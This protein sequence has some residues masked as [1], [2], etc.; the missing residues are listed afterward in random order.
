MSTITESTAIA[1]KGGSWLI[2]DTPASDIF[3]PERL[4]DEHRLIARTALDFIT[5]EV[6]PRADAL[7]AKDWKVARDLIKRCGDL[8]LMGTDV[9]EEF[10]GVDL[11]KAA[12][13]VVAEGISRNASFGTAFG[14]MTSLSIMPLLCFGTEAQKR[15][16][17][18][19]LVNGEIVG[20][21]ALS[22]SGSGSD[23]LG[24]KARATRQPDGSFRLNGEK[25]WI[26]NAGFADVF[27]VFAKVDGEQFT[28]FIVERGFPGVS[29]GKEEH[30]MGLHGSSTAPLI[31]QDAQVPADNLLGDIG[32]GHRVAFNVLNYGRFKLGAMA[33]G[34]AKGALA[35]AAK[36][37]ATR[38]QFGRALATF[39]AI[40]YKLAEMT[41]RLY[42]LESLLYR[43]SGLIDDAIGSAGGNGVAG[44]G[45]N[46]GASAGGSTQAH[47]AAL[48]EFA[49]ESSIAKV[50]GSEML[51]Y[52]IDEN[53]QIHGGNGYVRDYPAE[54]HYRDSRVNRIFEGTNEINRMLIT[55]MLMRRAVKG[56]IG[57]IAAAKALQDE[58]MTPSL[59]APGDDLLEA[60][61]FVVRS[62]KKVGLMLLGTAM[63]TYG[64]KVSD[65]QEILSW[66]SDV[67][68]DTFAGESAVLRALQS[69][70]AN[71]PT[72]ALQVDAARLFVS[73]AAL[74]I[75]AAA[76]QALAGMADGDTLR[77]LLAAL[78]RL[79]KVAPVNTITIRR[80]ISDA[81]VE[82][83]GYPLQF[84]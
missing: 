43:T 54:R 16:Y 59:D 61:Q 84:S 71:H 52:V 32:K 79:L 3:T 5:Q 62:F 46:G 75:E 30:K 29:N 50:A 17:L 27:I 60:E 77:V 76:R 78:R 1:R 69:H 45:A 18:P 63:Q 38:K 72:A 44:S 10:G 12:A 11:D 34:G 81:A 47:L 41:T 37:A 23:A 4:S 83:G 36:Y 42:A 24:A 70:A 51:H 26:T 73:D 31:L 39:G 56:D 80:R 82:K 35:E 67:L 6:M 53:V 13:V 33:C 48:E 57:L 74:R 68:I 7:E 15:K 9:P 65:E 25:M 8:G 49:V 19:G 14:A 21:Y 22:E 64:D 28:A 20:A 40:K 66:T 2:E 58:I 55:G